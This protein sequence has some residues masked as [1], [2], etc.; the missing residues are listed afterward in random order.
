M[1]TMASELTSSFGLSVRELAYGSIEE[2]GAEGGDVDD[3]GV[4]G[5]L[6]QGDQLHR[7]LDCQ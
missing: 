2:H 1:R 5:F 3:R 6:E 7:Q 4:V